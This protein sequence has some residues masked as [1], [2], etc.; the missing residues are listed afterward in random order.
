MIVRKF[1]IV[2]ISSILATQLFTQPKLEKSSVLS[3]ENFQII[4]T[5]EDTLAIL[6]YAVVND[7][8]ENERFAACHKLITLLVKTLKIKN[9]F[10]YKFDRLKT[11][12]ILAPPDSSFRIFTWQLFVNDST[13]KYYGCIQINSRNLKLFPLIDKSHEMEIFPIDEQLTN[14]KWLGGLY[15]GIHSFD[16][17]SGQKYLIFGYNAF[18]F[19]EKRKFIDVLSFDKDGKPIFGADVFNRQ[20]DN[21]FENNKHSPEMRI[22]LEYS[23]EATVRCNWDEQ[24]QMVLFDH[25]ISIPSPFGRGITNVPDGSVEGFKWEKKKW[26]YISKVFNDVMKPEETEIDPILSNRKNKDIIGRSK[27]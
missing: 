23:S 8:I 25:L 3:T 5:N 24:Y 19:F 2:I 4:K 20:Q 6:A 11:I 18:S 1:I 26:K 22:A 27:H 9:S 15:Y 21:K 7:S 12:S 10:C 14:E 16:T 17:K 13:Y